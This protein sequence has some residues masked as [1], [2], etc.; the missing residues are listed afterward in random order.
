[1]SRGDTENASHRPHPRVPGLSGAL[2]LCPLP[3]SA[4]RPGNPCPS[5]YHVHLSPGHRRGPAGRRVLQRG[6]AS[7]RRRQQRQSLVRSPKG[8]G[9]VP[10]LKGLQTRSLSS[11]GTPS[12]SSPAVNRPSDSG[13]QDS[14]G[15]GQCETHTPSRECWN[16]SYT[17]SSH[18]LSLSSVVSGLL[19]DFFPPLV[20]FPLLQDLP[21]F[22]GV[23]DGPA[24]S[25]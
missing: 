7:E 21:D 8:M 24:C 20:L 3:C 13:R 12:P 25:A 6:G 22:H 14:E 5:C 15:Q 18:P 19:Q 16:H 1:M 10:D 4:A 23:L 17:A 2:T 9:D 11:M